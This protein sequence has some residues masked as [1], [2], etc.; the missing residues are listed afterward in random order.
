MQCAHRSQEQFILVVRAFRSCG[1]AVS[2]M[3]NYPQTKSWWFNSH[4]QAL[5]LSSAKAR[6]LRASVRCFQ[7]HTSAD[8]LNTSMETRTH[9]SAPLASRMLSSPLFVSCGVCS[10]AW[11]TV[12]HVF[13]D[14]AGSQTFPSFEFLRDEFGIIVLYVAVHQD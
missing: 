4:N 10:S 3:E 11:E 12:F 13:A 1:G 8:R 9:Q 2:P 14:K 5:W 6:S 7:L